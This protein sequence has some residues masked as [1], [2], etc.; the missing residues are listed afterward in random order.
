MFINNYHFF[1]HTDNNIFSWE[2]KKEKKKKP[3]REYFM[4]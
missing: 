1:Q 3:N 4:Q 2:K